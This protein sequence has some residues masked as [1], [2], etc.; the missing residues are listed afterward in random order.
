M[1]RNGVIGERYRVIPEE[2]I[3]DESLLHIW[4]YEAR[5]RPLEIRATAKKVLDHWIELGLPFHP[6]DGA[7]FFD[8]C[9]VHNF[10]RVVGLDG[11]DTTWQRINVETVRKHVCDFA[12]G[13]GD[14]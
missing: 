14:S 10:C 11:R 3:L 5:S 2:R 6:R 1:T 13:I 12:E 4:P 7:R 9:E 8:K